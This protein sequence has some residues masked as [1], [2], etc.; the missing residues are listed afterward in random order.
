MERPSSWSLNLNLR[1]RRSSQTTWSTQVQLG[2]TEDGGLTQVFNGSLAFRPG[3]QWQ[4]SIGPRLR[5]QIDTQQYLTTLEGGRPE[6]FDMRYVFGTIDRNTYAVRFRLGYT[7]KPDLNL[8]VYAEPFAASGHYYDQGEL[9]EPSTRLR[10]IYGT[11][12]TTAVKQPDGSLLVTDGADAFT[13]RNSDFNVHSFRA[14]VVLRWEWRLGSTLFVVW[15]QDRRE[16]ESIGDRISLLDP[17]RSLTAP[18]NN[19]FVVKTTFW[20]SP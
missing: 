17:F 15:E 4:V 8:D 10:R 18:G 3:N 9:A 7:F 2:T 16:R 14:N 19:F 12:G 13:L 5:R 11:D 6:T 1:N 20:W